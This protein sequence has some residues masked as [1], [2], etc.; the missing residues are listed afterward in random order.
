M[1]RT[2]GE[3]SHLGEPIS[4]RSFAAAAGAL[5]LLLTACSRGYGSADR[6]GSVRQE[7]RR[8]KHG[9][10]KDACA[11]WPHAALDEID[12]LLKPYAGCVSLACT[13][14]DAASFAPLRGGIAID[15]T[16]RRT[17]ASLI[18]LAVL[19][20]ALDAASAGSLSLDERMT[21]T[22]GDIVGGA[23]DI[24]AKGAGVTYTV[25]ELLHA[26]IAQSDNTAAN[27]IIGRLGMDVVNDECSK[28]H[29][30]QTRLSRLMMDETARQ[31]GRENVM[32]AR[33]AASLLQRIAAGTVATPELCERARAYLL[34]QH[35]TAGIV[36]GLPVGVQVAHKTG[37]LDGVQ[38]DAAIVYGDR[39]YVLAAL[40]Q[41][42]EREAALG[43]MRDVSA[44]VW[45]AAVS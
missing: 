19:A 21:V 20:T 31:A 7:K 8:H 41:G 35:D 27:L 45:R 42:M 4:R 38:H 10:R 1:A 25:D 32:S 28:L 34:D 9:Q 40:T 13:P 33:D 16:V 5:P 22:Q 36:Q 12:D 3:F 11:T 39:P 23:G 14:L 37:S 26:M 15:A 29:L 30:K 43:L 6:S 18:K 17:A 44:A 24:Q 2:V